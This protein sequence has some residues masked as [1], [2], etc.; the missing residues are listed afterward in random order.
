VSEFKYYHV[1][2]D[3]VATWFTSLQMAIPPGVYMVQ[4][5]K[6]GTLRWDVAD[7]TRVA[8]MRP[9]PILDPDMQKMLVE[10]YQN[11]A[12]AMFKPG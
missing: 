3:V 4:L 5:L 6:D 2:P 1:D 12:K 8:D 11:Y 9:V 10:Y 7:G